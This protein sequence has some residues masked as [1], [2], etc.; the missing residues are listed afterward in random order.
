MP[1]FDHLA[2][3]RR[4][5]TIIVVSVIV[6]AI[7]VYFASPTLIDIMLDPIRAILPEGSE[8]T[9]LTALG[10]FSIRFKVS[11]FFGIIMCTPIILWQVLG[12]FLPALTEKERRWVTPTLS[13]MVGLFFLGMIFCYLVIQRAAFGWLIEQITQFA[14]ATVNAE[15]YL[16][17]MMLLEVGFGIAFQLPLIIFYL[18]I[19][20]VVPYR[21]FRGQ[22]RYV[23]VGLLALCGIVTPDASPITMILMY[24]VMLALY[25][26]SLAVARR[27]IVMRDGKEALYWTREE[28]SEHQLEKE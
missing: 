15:D 3:F 27:V 2:E 8:L 1:L 19:L 21:T 22:W 6:A 7:V 20:H 23:Y 25:E 9:V 28:Y 14:T 16:S 10:G 4:R 17:I 5:L 26:V 18:S 12:F 11:L 13:A 24:A